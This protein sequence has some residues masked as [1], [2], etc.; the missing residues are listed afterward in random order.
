[1]LAAS[2]AE[3]SSC[4]LSSDS[5][6]SICSFVAS[7]GETRWFD[8]AAPDDYKTKAYPS[9]IY[10]HGGGIEVDPSRVI[11]S[12]FDSTVPPADPSESGPES[13]GNNGPGWDIADR[14]VLVIPHG[15]ADDRM[16]SY[17][18]SGKMLLIQQQTTCS[19]MSFSIY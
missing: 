11:N 15:S 14:Y 1:M 17:G 19:L 8:I 13:V 16:R 7:D 4:K 2:L 9:I 10:F 12:K 3:K 6:H 5:T 18:L